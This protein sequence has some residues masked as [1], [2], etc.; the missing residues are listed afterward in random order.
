MNDDQFDQNP[1]SVAMTAAEFRILRERLGVTTEWLA[2]YL[3]VA[4]RT[5]RRWE[6]GHSVVPRAVALEMEGL[7]ESTERFVAAVAHELTVNPCP[8][9]TGSQWVTAYASDEAYAAQNPETGMSA[10]WHRAAMGRVAR[11]VPFVR[12][13]FI[14]ETEGDG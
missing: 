3:E 4:L 12:V 2:G 5:I 6:H 1:A 13:D 7:E 14:G 9:E 11:R 8:D 10:G